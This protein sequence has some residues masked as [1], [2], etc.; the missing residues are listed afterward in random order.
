MFLLKPY[1][2]Y[3]GGAQGPRGLTMGVRS[4]TD[5]IQER[6]EKSSHPSLSLSA[7]VSLDF[8]LGSRR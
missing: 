4:H 1:Y 8:F 2:I 6:D 5:G 7:L 3:Y